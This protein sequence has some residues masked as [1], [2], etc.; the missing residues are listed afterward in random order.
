MVRRGEV[1]LATLDP[2]VGSEIQKTR[3]C[4]IVSPPE[5]HNYLRTVLAA[6]LTSKGRSAASRVPVLFDGFRDRS[7]STRPAPWTSA[8]P[9]S[10]SAP[11]RR[12]CST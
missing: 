8:G 9:S 11:S 1:W 12:R 7:F 2:T 3:P 4:P 5:M 6:P 10:V